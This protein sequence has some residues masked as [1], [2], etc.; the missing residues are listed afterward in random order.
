MHYNTTEKIIG[1]RRSE[2]NSPHLWLAIYRLA[3]Y[4]E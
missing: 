1:W 3:I 4:Y 2:Q